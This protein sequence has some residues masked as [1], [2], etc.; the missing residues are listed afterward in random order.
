MVDDVLF[1]SALG[2]VAAF[3]SWLIR[4]LLDDMKKVVQQNTEALHGIE[5]IILSCQ[6]R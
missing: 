3:S 5:K 2:G 6:K 1:F 4:W